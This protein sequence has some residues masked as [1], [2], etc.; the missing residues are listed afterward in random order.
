MANILCWIFSSSFHLILSIFRVDLVDFQSLFYSIFMLLFQVDIW[1]S[2]FCKL[3]WL[4]LQVN[5]VHFQNQLLNFLSRFWVFSKS[6]LT[7]FQVNFVQPS[8]FCL[9]LHHVCPCKL[10]IGSKVR[11][12]QFRRTQNIYG[13]PSLAHATYNDP[14]YTV[15]NNNF[16]TT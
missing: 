11:I 14:H 8:W 16:G 9:S 4:I 1:L 13:A 12:H 7:S 15:Y 10:A 5:F 3:I 6:I 2:L